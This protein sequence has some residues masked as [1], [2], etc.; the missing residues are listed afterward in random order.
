M[1]P[2][3]V[4][5]TSTATATATSTSRP[6]RG[7]LCHS[8]AAHAPAT[9]TGFGSSG[10]P[11]RPAVVDPAAAG[12][13]G[14][15]TGTLWPEGR[16]GLDVHMGRTDSTQ[17]YAVGT[18]PLPWVYLL[19]RIQQRRAARTPPRVPAGQLRRSVTWTRS[20]CAISSRS[21]YRGSVTAFSYRCTV[22]RS[23]PIRS[24]NCS[25]ESS[26]A[27]RRSA[28]RLPSW[29]WRWRIQSGLTLRRAGTR[30]TVSAK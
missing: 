14:V 7:R 25:W 20:A 23:T 17:I 8:C 18:L 5:S 12:S 19:T 4:S 22:R 27:R 9:A 6:G 21:A 11:D 28:M 30:Q 10:S 1:F 24:A 13:H 15:R 26:A 2:A 29:R 16:G 3:P